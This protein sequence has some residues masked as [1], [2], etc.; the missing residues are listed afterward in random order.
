MDS[1]HALLRFPFEYIYDVLTHP[2]NE[3]SLIIIALLIAFG[4]LGQWVLY[5]K[6]DLP[7]I[8]CLVP[9]WNIMVFLRIMGRPSWQSIFLMVPPPVIAYLVYTGDT[10]MM[11]NI[12]LVLMLVTFVGFALLVYVELCKCFGKNNIVSYILCITLN[13]LYV[14]YLGMSGETEYQG[15]LYGPNAQRTSLS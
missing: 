1:L 9:V 6:C 2:N 14:M 5:Y 12:I 11:A 4:I 7:G 8:A 3:F 15:P 13:G 10:S